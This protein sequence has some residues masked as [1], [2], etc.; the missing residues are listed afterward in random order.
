MGHP[1]YQHDGA[2]FGFLEAPGE[3]AALM[4]QLDWS[5]T[6]L[7]PVA[8]WPQSL[9]ISIST[10]LG[11][12]FP[13]LLWW[14]PDLVML[15]NDAYRPILGDKHPKALGQA[16][17]ECWPEIWDIIGPM[18][19]GVRERGE[20]T[21]S[22]N[23]MLPLERRGYREEC[24][25]TFS[26]SPIRGDA[27]E[28]AGVFCAVNETTG[29]V[30]GARRLAMLRALAA[31]A[32]PASDVEAACAR[33]MEVMRAYPADIPFALLY[34]GD[35]D[36]SGAE[37]TASCG[38]E[39]VG[40]AVWPLA[41]AAGFSGGLIV[42]D[43]ATRL[44]CPPEGPWGEPPASAMVL[45]LRPTGGGGAVGG[46]LVAG[47]SARLALDDQYR[48]F[49]DL[50]AVQVSTA[51]ANAR[52]HEEE[53]RRAEALAELDRAKTAF[54]SNVSHEFRT[55]LTL[56]LGPLDDLL[57]A[58]DDLLE[59]DQRET[60]TLVRRNGQRMLRLVNTL[61]DFSRIEAGRLRASYE[62]T[63]LAAY[64]AELAS[65]FRSAAEKAGLRFVVDCPPLPAPVLVDRTM[66]EQI[67]F[68]LLS[69]ALKFTFHGEVAVVLRPVE[70]SA[71][72]E[73]RD[74][75]SGIAAD[76][77]PRLFERFYRVRG[78]LGRSTEG[79]GIGLA[80]VQELARLHGG[81]VEAESSPGVGSSF[82]VRVPL[83][84][85]E[86]P[87]SR[88]VVRPAVPSP[89]AGAFLDEALHWLP[90][91]EP[92]RDARETSARSTPG[93]EETV[94][95]ADDN[96]DMRA[97]LR[98]L[99]AG[100]YMVRDV[101][102]GAQ[103][104]AAA[105]TQPPDLVLADVMMPQLD[106][107]GLLEA[108]RADPRTARVPVVL[109]SARA[110]EEA[111]VEGLAAGADDYLVK[112]F[113]ARELL[114]RV[115]SH[116]ALARLRRRGEAAL[117]ESEARYRALAE[118]LQDADRRKDEF[119]AMLAHELRNPLAVM[120]AG[121]RVLKS[122]R[123]DDPTA[124]RAQEVME[125]QA[126]HM[127]RLIDD[128]LDV[129]RVTRGKVSLKRELVPLSKI[130]DAAVESLGGLIEARGQTLLVG[131]ARNPLLVDGDLVRLTQ[132]LTNV[133]GNA[134][135]Y[136][137]DGGRIELRV[138]R[139]GGDVVVVV[140]DDGA[141]IAPTLLPRVFDLFVQGDRAPDRGLGGLGI[142][143]TLAR[144]LV[145]LHGGTIEAS[146]GGVGMGSEFRIVLPLAEG[147]TPQVPRPP[148]DAAVPSRHILVVDD[149]RDAA[150]MMRTLLEIDGHR[151]SVA[152]DGQTA[153][154]LASADAADIALVDLGMPGMD[155]FEVARRMRSLTGRS[156]VLVALTGYGQDED[157]QRSRDAGFDHHLVKPADLDALRALLRQGAT[158]VKLSSSE[159][160]VPPNAAESR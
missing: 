127:E 98:R 66:W 158:G 117:R 21:W 56:M 126:R 88:E 23:L 145:E 58:A 99:L 14:G 42:D 59:P 54:F 154:R 92:V 75:G 31:A 157:V 146:S 93:S 139:R 15:Y 129:S 16:G 40:P 9:R 47:V 38:S 79:T 147:V 119:L 3:A 52:A 152:H 143:L 110:G 130:V 27:A 12:R 94:L 25:F 155:G 13:I 89:L 90:G 123:I 77:L 144:S 153:L 109:L 11:S 26:Y 68:N 124:R 95:L 70:R 137:P 128:L 104:L 46:F 55:P 5:R 18:L 24:Y 106:G 30:I 60:L 61:L 8:T 120:S 82:V 118:R 115:D 1:Q 62:P 116:L 102:D 100:R 71:V 19:V 39:P 142:G 74:T 34:L 4:R 65:V 105:L 49:L 133:L 103:A 160:A 33:S 36:P 48:G 159:P 86:L 57:S 64:T 78:A 141:G 72:L 43:L 150:E 132:A 96:A 63:D 83:G 53:R 28:V 149:N 37:L 51:I 136:T 122:A 85:R 135:K 151:V 20:A 84:E 112:P 81:T 22:E 44:V 107:F 131:T 101:A 41:E 140:S 134:A 7:G 113:S 73:V 138:E 29:H 45:P 148:S 87:A 156:T 80:L 125:R 121:A 114:A 10:C 6:P 32:G 97:Y 91:E 2:G 69:N 111:R 50:V 108:L 35:G 76:E 67:V 17:R